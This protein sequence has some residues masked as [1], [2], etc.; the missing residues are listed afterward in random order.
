[1]GGTIQ[2]PAIATPGGSRMKRPHTQ[3]HG[4]RLGTH[5]SA[6]RR[7]ALVIP[8][9]Q[10]TTHIHSIG[11]SGSG[12]SRFLAALYLNFLRNGIPATLIDPHGDLAHLVLS[13]LVASGAYDTDAAFERVLY[14]DFPAAERAGRFL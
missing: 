10:A 13:Y 12:K 6:W 5:G 3:P 11:V 1:M 14:L 2:Q 9:D 7:Q 8:R 4:L